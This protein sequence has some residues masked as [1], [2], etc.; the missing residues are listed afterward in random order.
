MVFPLLS[1]L[2]CI[3][4]ND[5]RA[6]PKTLQKKQLNMVSGAQLGKVR[7]KSQRCLKDFH[8]VKSGFLWSSKEILYCS[9][10]V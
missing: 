9:T 4:L 3:T 6:K 7:P 10:T 8:R 5:G 2:A 1:D